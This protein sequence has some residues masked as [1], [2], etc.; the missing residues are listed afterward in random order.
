MAFYTQAKTKAQVMKGVEGDIHASKFTARNTV[1]YRLDNGNVCTRLHNTT[2]C[3]I[4]PNGRVMLDTGG[5]P[6]PTT[7]DRMN[8]A[9]PTGWGV[10]QDKGIMYV[11]T[12]AGCFAH[13]DKAWYF[14]NGKPVKPTLHRLHPEKFKKDMKLIKAYCDKIN[15][16][17]P[18]DFQTSGDPFVAPED[19]GLYAEYYVREWLKERYVFGSI[20]LQA[21]N[22]AGHPRENC[23]YVIRIQGR[24]AQCVRRY[25][26]ACL[27]YAH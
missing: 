20:V 17:A 3:T 24:A 9:L 14:S 4:K 27:G 7:R 6:T 1:T 21:L 10:R 5:W 11:R 22:W 13:V 25:L 23:G 15:S 26:K 12:P 19:N 2:V 16:M 8:C 18:A